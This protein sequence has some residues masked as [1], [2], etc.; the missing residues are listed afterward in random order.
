MVEF[1]KMRCEISITSG[2]ITESGYMEFLDK[3]IPVGELLSMIKKYH[4]DKHHKLG[5]MS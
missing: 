1:K 2:S 5:E 4:G 3:T